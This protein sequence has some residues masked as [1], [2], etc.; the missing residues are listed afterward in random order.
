M[1]A[2][3][4]YFTVIIFELIF[5]IGF[6]LITGSFIYSSLKGSP[7]VP[8]RQR[9]IDKILSNA[10]LKAGQ[11]FFDLGCGDGRVARRAASIFKVNAVGVDVNPILIWYAR[12]LV[13]IHKTD[14]IKFIKEN[15]FST[16]LKN[17]DIVY[18]FL[19]PKL[20]SL[21]IPK[22]KKELKT[23]ALVISHGFTIVEWKNKLIKK[24][25]GK[26]FSTFYYRVT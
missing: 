26:P 5:A 1:L 6:T 4:L 3:I 17:A 11:F 15:I 23:G 25:D 2:V 16:D 9:V 21:L 20:I 24:I 13:K 10:A 18:L 14:N 19:M 22:L 8:T 12:I 7:Y